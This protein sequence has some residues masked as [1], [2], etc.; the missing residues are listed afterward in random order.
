MNKQ[1]ISFLQQNKKPLVII[2]ITGV[3]C[4]ILYICCMF[5]F[6]IHKEKSLS[7]NTGITQSDFLLPHADQVNPAEE[8]LLYDF[9]NG[10]LG[11]QSHDIDMF[12]DDA[13]VFCTRGESSSVYGV[14]K[15]EVAGDSCLFLSLPNLS[16][17]PIAMNFQTDDERNDFYS[18]IN[19]LVN[20]GKVKKASEGEYTLYVVPSALTLDGQSAKVGWHG[21]DLNILYSNH[22]PGHFG[23]KYLQG[24]GY[25]IDMIRKCCDLQ[26]IKKVFHYDFNDKFWDTYP[27]GCL[28]KLHSKSN[29]ND[30]L[31]VTPTIHYDGAAKESQYS[32]NSIFYGDI[33]NLFN[34]YCTKNS[35]ET[36]EEAS[37][38]P[39]YEELNSDTIKTLKKHFD[40]DYVLGQHPLIKFGSSLG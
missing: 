5:F 12:N 16:H 9:T 14:Y 13:F 11:Y 34:S 4:V 17:E 10:C 35:Y 29:P 19:D 27:F 38:N 20:K 21:I 8:P 7:Q 30:C 18:S 25:S 1:F 31:Y 23:K 39:D 15:A 32:F 3:L 36:P 40:N 2:A 24:E 33:L 6:N 28:L 37:K 26:Y 22:T